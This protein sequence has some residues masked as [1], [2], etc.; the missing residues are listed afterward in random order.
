MGA[1]GPPARIL[2]VKLDHGWSTVHDGILNNQ[3]EMLGALQTYEQL[4]NL[5]VNSCVKLDEQICVAVWVF[6]MLLMVSIEVW[7]M[8]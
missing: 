3:T 8:I 7:T 4:F 2:M 1:A 6:Y 5:Y